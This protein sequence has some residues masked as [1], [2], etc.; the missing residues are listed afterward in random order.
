VNSPLLNRTRS[1][2]K[3]LGEMLAG[4]LAAAA[5]IAALA[6][7]PAAAQGV[8]TPDGRYYDAY[9]PSA[10]KE[11]QFYHYTCEFDAAWVV[12][13]TFGYDVGFDELIGIVGHDTSIEPYYEETAEGFV[14]YGGDITKAFNGN[15]H[16]N[17]L[18]RTTG[19][20]M[21]P[22]FQQYNLAATP[23]N[24][25]EGIEQ[26][27]N[28]GGLVWMKATADFLPWADTTWITPNGDQLPTVLGND[29]AVVV[30]GYNE[31]GPVI[32]D[33]LGPTS[34]NWE[35]AYEYDVPWETFLG[36]FN[37]QGADGIGVLPPGAGAAPAASA[38]TSPPPA[39]T[40]PADDDVIQPSEAAEV[41][42]M[43]C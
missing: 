10:S 38:A 16:D 39:E 41:V 29:H 15:Y 13:A 14:I 17:L 21:M 28:Q 30:M 25:R 19:Q 22:I 31:F 20:A 26:T 18:A 37:A 40:A 43:C 27:L 32:R 1:R 24:S 6:P 42:R 9:V 34:S 12:L 8:T 33:V 23:V 4:T 11:G 36:V 5:P 3:L 7:R 35:R 2:R